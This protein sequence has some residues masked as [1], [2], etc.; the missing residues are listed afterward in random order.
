MDLIKNNRIMLSRIFA[1]ILLIVLITST[2]SWPAGSLIDITIEFIGL[3]LI[4]IGS[5]GRIWSYLYI[6]GRKTGELVMIGPYS[7]TRNP[8]YFFSLIGAIGIGFAS[9]NILVIGLI[10]LFFILIYPI[11]IS[12]EEKKLEELHGDAFRDYKNSVPR[13]FPKTFTV[14]HPELYEV[15]TRQFRRVFFDAMWFVW[16]FIIMQVIEKLHNL[17]I[18]PVLWK[19]P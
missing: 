13:L 1:G 10:L 9:E 17:E 19:V 16:L 4:I 5:Y 2:H 18:I 3:A 14:Q 11:I 7:I 15:H 6:C 12:A 8:L